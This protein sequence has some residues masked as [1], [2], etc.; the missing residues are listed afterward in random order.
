MLFHL[1]VYDLIGMICYTNLQK[2]K[3]EEMKFGWSYHMGWVAMGSSIGLALFTISNEC[4]EP[5]KQPVRR[6]VFQIDDG[7]VYYIAQENYEATDKMQDVNSN[8]VLHVK[9]DCQVNP[10]GLEPTKEQY[11]KTVLRSITK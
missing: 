11:Q 3:P 4:L 10:V 6:N 2:D 5:V 1:A 8:Q 7:P 9:N